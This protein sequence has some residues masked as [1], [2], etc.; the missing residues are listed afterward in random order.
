MANKNPIIRNK[1]ND[2]SD[3]Q[4][5]DLKALFATTHNEAIAKKLKKTIAAIRAKAVA[6]K[7]KKSNRYWHTAWEKWVLKNYSSLAP[8]EMIAG[9]QKKFGIEKTKWAVINKYRELK[10]LRKSKAE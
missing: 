9:L 10:G 4:E 7:L 6:L 3:K 5:E 8:D 1:A 2:W